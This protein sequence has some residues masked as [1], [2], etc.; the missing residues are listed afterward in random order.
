MDNY[1]TS[2]SLKP[3]FE[4]ASVAIIGASRTPGKGGYNIVE[5][6]LRLGY[7]GQIYPIN[8]QA[9]YILGL[10]VYSNLKDTPEPPELALMTAF[11]SWTR[12]LGCA[13]SS[14]A[15]S[16]RLKGYASRPMANF[17]YSSFK[18]VQAV[19]WVC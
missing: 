3:F 11:L 13:L 6:L 17:P 19:A 15:T 14:L 9:K 2:N 18:R 7:E 10:P 4:P 5:N 1:R 8:P 12:L 16:S